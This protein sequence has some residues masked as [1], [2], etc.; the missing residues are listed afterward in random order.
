MSDMGRSPSI[1]QWH[2]YV[3]YLRSSNFSFPVKPALR[4]SLAA[5][6]VKSSYRR[7]VSSKLRPLPE[8]AD[9]LTGAAEVLFDLGPY[10]L[11]SSITSSAKAAAMKTAENFIFSVSLN[12]LLEFLS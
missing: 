2:P 11:L 7:G 4:K 1:K 8:R 5:M 9:G 12:L 6:A 10:H 3:Q